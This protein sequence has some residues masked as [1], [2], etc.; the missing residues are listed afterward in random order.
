MDSKENTT[1][2]NIYLLPGLGADE[3]L[4]Q[5]WQI[6]DA[7]LHPIR[8]LNPKSK[9]SL[10]AYVWRLTKQIEHENPILL[11]HSLGGILAQEMGEF[12]E[13]EK[14][15]I[16]GSIK[17]KY[18]RPP[19]F[20]KYKRFPLHRF[21][22]HDHLNFV[23]PKLEQHLK[24]K[25]ESSQLYWSML[26]DTD[27]SFLQWGFDKVVQWERAESLG[28]LFHIQGTEDKIF[29]IKHLHPPF[30]QI[31]NLIHFPYGKEA[32]IC[33]LIE[34]ILINQPYLPSKIS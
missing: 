28:N 34:K 31:Q 32:E 18:E 12:I 14:V 1:K 8:Y 11:G 6:A 13:A 15:I 16:L 7:N 19:F 9:E 21:F 22:S 23:I 4:F 5:H 3:R 27:N 25:A 10:E 24:K 17:T 30:Y 20:K 29:P 26:N 2:H 33:A